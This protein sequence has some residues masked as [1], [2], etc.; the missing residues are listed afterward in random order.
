MKL[1]NLENLSP[2]YLGFIQASGLFLYI[3]LVT[4]FMN[5][6]TP[7][8]QKADSA[9]APL[10]FIMLFVISAVISASMVLG[11]AGYLFWEKRYAEAFG[12][13]KWTISWSI[14]YFVFAILIVSAVSY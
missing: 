5:G 9:L 11:R 4:S 7:L 13:L 14:L 3:F 10:V 1:K 12:L 8:F 2:K 6:I